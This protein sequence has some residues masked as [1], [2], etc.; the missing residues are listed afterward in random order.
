MKRNSFI[1]ALLSVFVF[2]I[3][4][5]AQEEIP[6]E[7]VKKPVVEVS[8]VSLLANPGD[9]NNLRIKTSGYFVYNFENNALY[10]STESANNLLTKNG[11]WVEL[12]EETGLEE[13]I[14]EFKNTFCIIEGEFYAEEKGH[15]DL[16][17]ASLKD[18]DLIIPL[19]RK[20]KVDTIIDSPQM[21]TAEQPSS[22]LIPTKEILNIAMEAAKNQELNLTNLTMHL[23]KTGWLVLL[24][25]LAPEETAGLEYLTDRNYQSIRFS[26]IEGEGNDEWF[27]IDS[28]S[29]QIIGK[30]N[31]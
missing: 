16:W 20:E 25:S 5:F 27:F 12:S 8:I 18:V 3:C 15:K 26:I 30:Y 14:N 31:K 29:G 4:S 21:S 6:I 13:N 22:V 10:L 9:Y 2:S 23:D 28:A 1:I 17:T 7:Q 11:L 24:N 19:R